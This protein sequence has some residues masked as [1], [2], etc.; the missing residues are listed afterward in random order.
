MRNQEDSV[1]KV[2]REF[3]LYGALEGLNV[4]YKVFCWTTH[5][6]NIFG[7][8]LWIQQYENGILIHVSQINFQLKTVDCTRQ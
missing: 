7:S 1:R 2:Q 4:I 6:V 3:S 8:K 5:I